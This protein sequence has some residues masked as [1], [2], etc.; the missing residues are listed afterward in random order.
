LNRYWGYNSFLPLQWEAVTAIG[1]RRDSLVILPTGGGKSVCFQLPV[2]AMAGTAIVI[3]PLVS[4]MKDQ[5]DTLRGLGI[6]AAYLNS[7]MSEEERAQTLRALQAGEYQ[8]LYVAPE[9][10]AGA[11]FMAFL[12]Q[13]DIAYFVIDEAHCI[14]QWGHDFRPAYRELSRLRREF[15]QLGIHAFTATATE[16]VRRDIIQALGLHQPEVHIGNFERANLFYRVQHRHDLNKQVR[17]IIDRH[18]NEG[19]IIYCISRKDV[20]ELAKTLKTQGYNVLPY[21]AGLSDALRTSNQEAFLREQVDI[22][23]ATV[24]FG[25]GIDRSNIRYVI[26]TGMPKSIENYQQE[27]GRAGRD[28]LEAE[29][30]LLYSGSDVGKWRTIMGKPDTETDQAALDKLYEMSNYCQRLLC[31]HKFLVEY[32]GQP[33]EKTNCGHCDACLGEYETLPDSLTVALKILSCVARLKERFGASHVAQVLR[34]ANTEKIQQFAHQQ[35]S[36]YGLLSEYRAADIT[37]W[38]D[39]L[40][41]Q[42]FLARE[43]QYNSLQLTPSGLSMLKNK[44]GSAFLVKPVPRKESSKKAKAEAVQGDFDA[45][46][47][48]TL[49]VLRKSLAIEQRVPPYII[50]SDATLRDMARRLPTS[51]SAFRQIKGV[52]EAKM[53]TLAPRFLDAILEFMDGKP[54]VS[55][56]SS[57]LGEPVFERAEADFSDSQVSWP[58]RA[59]RK[60]N[61]ATIDSDAFH[62]E[63]YSPNESDTGQLSD[64][65][66]RVSQSNKNKLSKEEVMRQFAEGVSFDEVLENSGKALS[67]VVE[68]LC[69]YLQQHAI[70]R[71]EPWV[72][73]STYQAVCRAVFAL[74][75]TRM[76]P[77]YEAL[78]EQV[79]Y[80]EIRISLVLI[81]NSLWDRP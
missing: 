32:F 25:M 48:E 34:G 69:E 63:T 23:V 20:D 39:Q 30:V 46:L 22:V 42:E 65:P 27:A 37:Q 21:H 76:K 62:L 9:R 56:E 15:P 17:Q 16:P 8:L 71:P 12:H 70:T 73:S 6:A 29:C 58:D 50:F 47:F 61:P 64:N 77:L 24:A 10:F 49:R 41:H 40:V 60:S 43:P 59:T 78:N 81:Q 52:G 55:S 3:S 74:G 35:L 79:S 75:G 51:L 13:C 72:S 28:R 33:Y 5:V 14:S 26:H 67:T 18:P 80:D 7:A 38:I 36:T 53:Q 4:L 54:S 45:A 11:D 44:Q 1:A 66:A 31:R 57:E 19:G 2:L 68:H